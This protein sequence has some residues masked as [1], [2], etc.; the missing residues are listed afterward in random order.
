MNH[1]LSRAPKACEWQTLLDQIMREKL[2][3]NWAAANVAYER[4]MTA[5]EVGD[6]PPW[7]ARAVGTIDRDSLRAPDK[8]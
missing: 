5:I 6:A 2:E 4:A 7:F 3:Q 1:G 8:D